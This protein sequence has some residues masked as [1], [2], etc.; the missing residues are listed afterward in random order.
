MNAQETYED[1]AK[2]THVEII[3]LQ[4]DANE[5]LEKAGKREHRLHYGGQFISGNLTDCKTLILSIN[6]GYEISEWGK[7]NRGEI[8]NKEYMPGQIKYIAEYCDNP[9]AKALVDLVFDGSLDA[10]CG[11]AE[12][13]MHSPFAS[14]SQG[15]INR[16]LKELD[17]EL[18]KK[19]DEIRQRIVVEAVEH[20]GPD[21]ILMTGL[22]VWDYFLGWQKKTD[23]LLG[24]PGDVQGWVDSN[25]KWTTNSQNHDLVGEV[26]IPDGPRIFVCKHLSTYGRLLGEMDTIRRRARSFFEDR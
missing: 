11:C 10:L 12:T 9:F 15:H 5:C 1:I 25:S 14:P 13:Y 22:G 3:D 6:P 23:W 26:F 20:L 21:N 7:P 24:A 19:H 8:Y 4:K 2:K 17:L 18:Q 16:A